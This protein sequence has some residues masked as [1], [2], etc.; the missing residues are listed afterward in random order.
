MIWFLVRRNQASVITNA[1]DRESAKKH[2]AK[3]LF[4]NPD[5]YEVTPITRA[6]ETVRLNIIVGG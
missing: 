5:E 2:A 1:H 4:H 6:G 3:Y